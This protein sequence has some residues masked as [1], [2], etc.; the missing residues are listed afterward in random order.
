MNLIGHAGPSRPRAVDQQTLLRE[1]LAGDLEPG[2]DRGHD[3]GA[4]AL[5]VVVEDPVLLGVVDQDP[6]GV[7]RPEVLKVQQGVGEQLGGGPQVQGDE[8]VV[9]LA[10]HPG[11]AV[12]Q[13]GRVVE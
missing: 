1:P 8:L 6:P 3:D 10:V 2:E 9:G 5:H 11:V 13:V 7:R 4:R 12:A